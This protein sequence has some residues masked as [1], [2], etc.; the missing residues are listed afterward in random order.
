MRSMIQGDP[1]VNPVSRQVIYIA[2]C[3]VQG[4]PDPGVTWYKVDAPSASSSRFYTQNSVL[5][6]PELEP[7]LDSGLYVC[8]ASNGVEEDLSY[9]AGGWIG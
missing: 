7:S 4:K 6:F 8:N 3:D 2:Q 1:W 5:V 9:M